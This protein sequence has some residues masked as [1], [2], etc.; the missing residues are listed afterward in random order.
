MAVDEEGTEAA[1]ATAVIVGATSVM[2]EEEPL[3]MI[4]NHPFMLLIRD[5]ESG[6]ILFLGNV[7][8]P[9]N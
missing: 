4:F 5:R 7:I 3:E 2:P 6:L 9:A 8:N 1:A